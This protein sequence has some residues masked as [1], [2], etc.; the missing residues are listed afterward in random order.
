[1][2]MIV[3]ASHEQQYQ[4]MYMNNNVKDVHLIPCIRHFL[5]TI[6]IIDMREFEAA[7]NPGPAPSVAGPTE[8]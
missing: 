5:P 6:E 2:A 1:M 7:M 8:S 4:Q 3:C